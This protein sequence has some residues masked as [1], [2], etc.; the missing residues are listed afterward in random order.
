MIPLNLT[1][2]NKD[3]KANLPAFVTMT[4]LYVSVQAIWGQVICAWAFDLIVAFFLWK[5]YKAVYAL[6]RKYF[7]SSDYQRSLHARTLMVQIFPSS[8]AAMQHFCTNI[9]TLVLG[10]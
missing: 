10:H 9:L 2:S 1:Q 3:S 4:P 6:R 8:G 5:N 7:Q